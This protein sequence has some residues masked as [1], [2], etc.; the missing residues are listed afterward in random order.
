M[1][2]ISKISNLLGQL[3][4]SLQSG[5]RSQCAAYWA[6]DAVL[7]HRRFDERIMDLSGRDKIVL[8]LAEVLGQEEDGIA[9]FMATPVIDVR[10]S[11]AQAR[12]FIIRSK[13][14]G[15]PQIAGFSEVWDKLV[16]GSDDRW[17]ITERTLVI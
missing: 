11:T 6:R 13:I 16:F 12:S 4:L 14:G 9:L 8:Y 17:L 5:D 10:G 1:S 7:H 2:A 15:T 3:T